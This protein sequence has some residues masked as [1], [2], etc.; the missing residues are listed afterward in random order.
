MDDKE[1]LKESSKYTLELFN[2]LVE[3]INKEKK[4][5][6]VIYT[7]LISL[8]EN[9]IIKILTDNETDLRGNSRSQIIYEICDRMDKYIKDFEE[10]AN[11]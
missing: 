5:T 11:G 10:K 6:Y 7:S 1:I 2:H 8:C 4:D 9:I 3:K